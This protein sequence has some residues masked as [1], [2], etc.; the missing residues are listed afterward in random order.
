MCRVQI[1]T[2]SVSVLFV[3]IPLKKAWI[4][5]HPA[6]LALD[7]SLSSTWGKNLSRE[8]LRLK[9]RLMS[10][11]EHK[12]GLEP[13]R[14]FDGVLR[15][16]FANRESAI[17]IMAI[18]GLHRPPHYPRRNPTDANVNACCCCRYLRHD[19]L[20]NIAKDQVN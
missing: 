14:L 20:G 11:S 17:G 6:S 3:L 16:F 5:L 2:A 1:L 18:Q 7:R 15:H 19:Y 9:R 10:K 4:R 13:R 12:S 8:Y